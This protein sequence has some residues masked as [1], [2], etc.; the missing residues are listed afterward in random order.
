MTNKKADILF[1][2]R[3]RIYAGYYWPREQMVETRLAE[4]MR[5]SR[6]VIRD[7]LKE[8]EV[9]GLVTI[10]PNR[11]SFVAELSYDRMKETLELEAILEGSAAYL[12]TPRLGTKQIEALGRL[13]QKSRNLPLDAIQSWA[14]YNWE[15]HR[16]IL[17][18]CGNEKLIEMIRHNVRFVK[19]WFVQLS[20]PEEI[21]QRNLGHEDILSVIKK[22]NAA[23]VRE[24]MEAHLM[25]AAEELIKRI[26]S[27]APNLIRS[28]RVRGQTPSLVEAR[29]V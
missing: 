12:A 4:E 8:L 22:R 1:R 26:Q 15:F 13:L 17:T 25:F 11:G 10:I 21:A 5:V 9:M 23:R 18:A 2:I 3:D 28:D 27:T 7:V 16:T 6:T 24:L 14:K 20:I 29:R 19:Y